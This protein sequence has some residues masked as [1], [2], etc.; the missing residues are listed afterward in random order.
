MPASSPLHSGDTSS[1]SRLSLGMPA[2]RPPTPVDLA[3][4]LTNAVEINRH[5][6]SSAELTYRHR[7][8]D[9]ARIFLQRVFDET[10]QLLREEKLHARTAMRD[11]VSQR[12]NDP[13][14]IDQRTVLI[15]LW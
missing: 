6:D 8:A 4:Y 15:Q 3:T 7:D 9:A 10:D 14:A 5:V 13:A 2:W 11:Y 12:L 1:E